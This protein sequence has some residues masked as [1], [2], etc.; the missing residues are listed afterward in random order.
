MSV[1]IYELKYHFYRRAYLFNG[2]Y[3]NFFQT[4]EIIESYSLNL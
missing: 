3:N 4:Y 1:F 2:K